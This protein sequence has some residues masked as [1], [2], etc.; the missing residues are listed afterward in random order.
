LPGVWRF[1]VGE[2]CSGTGGEVRRV[3][4]RE[5]VNRRDLLKLF[6]AGA[7]AV[8]LIG[9]A[10]VMEAAA[11]IIEP[12]KV[13]LVKLEARPAADME[14]LH[15]MFLDAGTVTVTVNIYS[16]KHGHVRLDPQKFGM[17]RDRPLTVNFAD[18][19][20]AEAQLTSFVPRCGPGDVFQFDITGVFLDAP[21]WDR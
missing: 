7:S 11:T 16:R 2:R 6:G 17:S 12:P 4:G 3:F 19:F 21:R 13:E 5:I 8:P 15:R 20:S 1:D 10:P 18:S 14:R 9:G